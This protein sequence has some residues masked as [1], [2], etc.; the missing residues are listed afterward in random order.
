[1]PK[2]AILRA[3][4]DTAQSLAWN[5]CVPAMR[6]ARSYPSRRCDLVPQLMV[7]VVALADA[8]VRECEALPQRGASEPRSTPVRV[9]PALQRV[10]DLATACAN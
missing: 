6:L 10:L 7:F 3:V 5:L 2:I 4:W 8:S 9:D 1:M